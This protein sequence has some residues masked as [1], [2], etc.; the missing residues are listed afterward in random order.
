MDSLYR[1]LGF[2]IESCSMQSEPRHNWFQ[3]VL[4]LRVLYSLSNIAIESALE[5][6]DANALGVGNFNKSVIEEGMKHRIFHLDHTEWVHFL[7]EM[8]TADF[9]ALCEFIQQD[10]GENLRMSPFWRFKE[11]LETKVKIKASVSGNVIVRL[12]L[13]IT[14]AEIDVPKAILLLLTQSQMDNSMNTVFEIMGAPIA[15][16]HH[17]CVYRDAVAIL[18][19]WELS[20][21]SALQRRVET[22]ATSFQHDDNT[23]ENKANLVGRKSMFLR[24]ANHRRAQVSKPACGEELAQLPDFPVG[25]GAWSRL[26]KTEKHVVLLMCLLRRASFPSFMECMSRFLGQ[27]EAEHLL[28]YEIIS[29]RAEAVYEQI[30]PLLGRMYNAIDTQNIV[31]TSLLHNFSDACLADVI[32]ERQRKCMSFGFLLHLYLSAFFPRNVQHL[33]FKNVTSDFNKRVTAD[34]RMQENLTSFT[35]DALAAFADENQV[36][37]CIVSDVLQ[38]ICV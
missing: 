14:N 38:R 26:S 24:L 15:T 19:H 30:M 5:L 8:N 21:S 31:I 7:S 3:R 37:K 32:G 9:A 10:Y 4:M 23:C 36:A 2:F 1:K 25:T 34:L 6:M 20:A 35:C 33:A 11:H 18:G 16:Q 13:L 12:Y 22:M 17:E 29:S 28:Y 27:R